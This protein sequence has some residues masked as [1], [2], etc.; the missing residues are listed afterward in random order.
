MHEKYPHLF[1]PIKIGNLVIKNRIESSPIAI[2]NDSPEF[3]SMENM[4]S[5]ELRG[6]SGAGLVVHEEMAVS[7]LGDDGS[8]PTF[9]DTALALQDIMKESE[10]VHRYGA[11]SSVSLTHHGGWNTLAVAPD[12]KLYAPSAIKNPYGIMTTEMN[13]D[14]I[15]QLVEA[16]ARAA[17][18]AQYGGHDMVMIHGAHGWLL[19]QFMSPLYN[20][21]KDKYGGSLENRAR[22]PLMIVDAIRKRCP[23]LPIEYRFSGNDHMEGGFGEEEAI[24]FAKMLDGKVD[25]IHITSSSFY[26]PSCGWLFPGMF[27]PVGCNI[28][29]ASRIK[30][31]IKTPVVTVG[32]ISDLEQ[33][34][35]AIANG[36]LDMVAAGRAFFADPEWVRKVYHG[37]EEDVAPC[38]RCGTCTPGAYG[39]AHYTPFHAHIRKC[40]VNPELGRE[41]Q[42]NVIKPG[43]RQKVLVIGGGPGGM[44]A[45]ITAHDR[46]HEVIL[47]EKSDRLGG[48]I[49]VV[50]AA[51]FKA[52]Y[53][54]YIDR[55][56]RWV[57]ARDIDLRMNT[58][59]TPEMAKEI[60]A[61]VIIAAVGAKPI[62][63][64]F[65]GADLPHVY[66]VDKVREV[67]VGQNVV[68]IGGGPL[69][70]EEGL[71]FAAQGKNVTVVEMRGEICLGAPYLHYMAVNKEYKKEGAPTALVNTKCKSI[72]ED[73]VWVENADGEEIFLKADTV[74][75]AIGMRADVDEVEAYRDCALEF[76]KIGDCNKPATMAEAIRLAY[77]AAFGL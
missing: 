52:E 56:I 3:A 70:A 39:P 44:Q 50:A 45:A 71:V 5:Y 4:I 24:E 40:S 30:H 9:C 60:G 53:R 33:A 7:K 31:A 54:K 15:E 18:M 66:T 63:P 2:P 67:E 29:M 25:L 8:G 55:Q 46:G 19:S 65:P 26:D 49:N 68:I 28:P 59:V 37:R 12:G 62:T 32:R 42:K 22:F 64:P 14:V 41:W 21:R 36:D 16:Y 1:S 77:D 51:P 43:P 75:L 23:K 76:R 11:I 6:R 69:G 58:F 48:L 73:G 35:R 27:A 74:L 10:A 57:K 17:E 47:C 34:D 72:T 13:E 61:D 38:L 20:H